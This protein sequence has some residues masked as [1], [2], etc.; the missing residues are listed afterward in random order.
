MIRY[1][2][3]RLATRRLV[4]SGILTLKTAAHIGGAD[5]MTLTDQPILKDH[6]GVPFIP[7]TTLA[8]LFRS[9]L[10]DA[11]GGGDGEDKPIANLLG[12]RWGMEDEDQSPLMIE[13]ACMLSEHIVNMELRD[14]VKIDAATGTAEKHKKFD[15]Q[16]LPSGT[17]FKLRFELFLKGDRNEDHSVLSNFLWLLQEL[18]MGRIAI[19]SRTRRG[20]GRCLSACWTY[21]HVDL[22]TADGLFQWLGLDGGV[23]ENWPM[24]EEKPHPEQ[25]EAFTVQDMARNLDV[26]IPIHAAKNGLEISLTLKSV[27]SLLIGSGGHLAEEADSVHLHR[28]NQE[29]NSWEPII[30]GTS[31]AG[32]LRNRSTK[33]LNTLSNQT[34]DTKVR[35]FVDALFGPEMGAGNETEPKASRVWTEESVID[36]HGGAEILR[37]TRT[38]IDRW[39]GG[40]LENMLIQ[41][42]ALFGG[43]VT[44]KWGVEQPAAEEIG[45]FLALVKDLFTGDLPVGGESSIG[46]GVLYGLH[47]T[48]RVPQPGPTFAVI[49]IEGDG[50][51]RITVRG[52]T[53]AYF[54]ALN[55]T[56]L[57]EETVHGS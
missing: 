14:G 41:E 48:V 43:T 23:P 27:G 31:L 20:F 25:R 39:R 11:L 38:A 52:D 2:E 51:G 47:G 13:D 12:C 9:H 34:V 57:R 40:A 49:S 36:V 32:I 45:L 18:E 26:S 56:F 6:L 42:D 5:V 8:G 44:L 7:G 22:L 28:I 37:H 1:E 4:V 21:Q 16:L 3:A 46:R 50:A 53:S 10:N 15:I 24:I 35:Q 54:E 29:N 17:R 55:Q 33:I 19:G 30:S